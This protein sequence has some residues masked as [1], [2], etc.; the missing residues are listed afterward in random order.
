MTQNIYGTIGYTILKNDNHN[1]IVFADMHDQLL[2]CNNNITISN[3]LKNKFDTSYILLEEVDRN[4]DFKL[5]ELWTESTHTQELKKLYLNN[6]D[7]ILPVDIRPFL[8]PYNWEMD[9]ETDKTLLHEYLLLIDNF[10]CINNKY[11]KKQI[12]N[13]NNN[14]L[15]N[16]SGKHYIILKYKYYSFLLKYYKLL[17]SELKD[18][19]NNILE[20]INDLLNDI[21]E[22]YICSKIYILQNKSNIIH[23]G[24]AHSQNVIKLLI[25]IY[26]YNIE[27]A[28]GINVIDKKLDNIKTG[29]VNII[30]KY[31]KLFG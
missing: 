14:L 3:W 16:I 13:Y 23:T 19:D 31:D 10:F 30:L 26:K 8:I 12:I 17:Y 20:E 27:T 21:M 5:K 15:N 29:C 9:K 11:I 28:S 22:W 7:I 1:V 6:K 25:Q 18:I 4:T 2:D 24:L